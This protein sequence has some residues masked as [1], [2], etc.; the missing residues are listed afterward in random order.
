M[1]AA[2]KVH[3][4]YAESQ[5][6]PFARYGIR[7]TCSTDDARSFAPPLD[8]S[9][10]MLV[11]FRSTAFTAL[12]LDAMGRVGCC[13]TVRGGGPEVARVGNRRVW[14]WGRSFSRYGVV[15]GSA[16]A[17]GGFN[18]SNQGLLMKKLA[19]S[20]DG[21]VAVVNSSLLFGAHNRV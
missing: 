10:P 15:P 17:A 7:Y 3:L 4:V 2:G 21:D 8:I 20:S 9:R 1:D 6:G 12:A 18:G 19:V 5:A 11:G 14:K 16:G 13:G